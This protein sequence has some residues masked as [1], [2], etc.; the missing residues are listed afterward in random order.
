MRRVLVLLQ[1][2]VLLV[3]ANSA[4]AHEGNEAEELGHH[5]QTPAYLHE[6]HLQLAAIAGIVVVIAGVSAFRRVLG[7]R[8][9]RQ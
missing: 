2:A 3:L 5:W 4:W 6:I 8:S 9:V 7:R 1:T